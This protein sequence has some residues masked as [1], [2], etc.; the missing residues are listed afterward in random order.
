MCYLTSS[1]LYLVC[2][3]LCRSVLERFLLMTFE[4]SYQL[5][6]ELQSSGTDL[7]FLVC[8][9]LGDP[10]GRGHGGSLSPTQ[11]ICPLCVPATS[12]SPSSGCGG[13][14]K[15]LSFVPLEFPGGVISV[16][17]CGLLFTILFP[18]LFPDISGVFS[19]NIDC[20][21]CALDSFLC[22]SEGSITV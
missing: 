12:G 6:M 15:A 14:G 13:G 4:F 9:V 19:L 10:G 16:V 5:V 2:H 17:G 21:P 7:S 8:P 3:L 20:A 11:K 1:C 22:N 18:I